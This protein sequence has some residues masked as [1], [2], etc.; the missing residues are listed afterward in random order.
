MP[1][2]DDVLDALARALDPAGD[3]PAPALGD[4]VLK[5]HQV[6]A[7]REIRTA[8]REFGGALLADDPGLGKTF[9]ALAIAADYASVLVAAPSA[10]QAMWMAAAARTGTTIGFISL[11]ALSRGR[12]AEPAPLLIVD[13]A[14]HAANPAARRYPALCLLAHRAHV[15]LLSATPVRNSRSELDALLGLFVGSRS[16]DAAARARCTIR[17]RVGGELDVPHRDTRPAIVVPMRS[18]VAFHLRRLPP[19]LPVA[20]GSAATGIVR[21]GLARCWA[22]S[23]AALDRALSRRLQR[24]AALRAS[25]ESGR[26]PTRSEL[27]AWVVG[28]DAMQLAFPF[29]GTAQRAD[30]AACETAL[31]RHVRAIEALRNVIRP[32]VQRDTQLRAAELM[33]ICEHHNGAVVIA[34]TS[35]EATATALFSQ[36]RQRPGTVLLTSGG[37]R[38]AAGALD[39]SWVIEAL[40]VRPVDA[41]CGSDSNARRNPVRLVIATDLLA[42]GV[43]LQGVSVVVHLDLP[44]TPAALDQRVGRAARIGS[45]HRTVFE[46]RFAAPKGAD[47]LLKFAQLQRRKSDHASRAVAPGTAQERLR[48]AT[49]SWRA[50]VRNRSPA[51]AAAVGATVDGFLACVESASRA[52]IV[53]GISKGSTASRVTNDPATLALLAEAV[54]RDDPLLVDRREVDR[55]ASAVVRWLSRREGAVRAGVSGSGRGESSLGRRRVLARLDH[56]L[57]TAPSSQLPALA[58]RVGRIRAALEQSAGAAVELHLVALLGSPSDAREWL[59]DLDQRLAGVARRW[60]DTWGGAQLTSVLLLRRKGRTNDRA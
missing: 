48:A 55:V 10:L 12:T 20:G 37:T 53:G 13:E 28:D 54:R 41:L 16:L 4:V 3:A 18:P 45:L 26:L 27:R 29:P 34:F 58:A 38:S 50:D 15:L 46:Y 7:V 32:G 43:N 22:S 11:E 40:A 24:G 52:W 60:T 2:L 47:Q 59:D 17:R 1:A 30:L 39:R 31:E 49:R 56:L 19:P 21:A 8:F 23:L 36:I 42:E 5:P 14:H 6:A 44:W 57:R 25:L 51:A 35:F 33:A 9:V